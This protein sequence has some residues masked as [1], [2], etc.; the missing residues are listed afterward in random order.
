MHKCYSP[1][2]YNLDKFAFYHFSIRIDQLKI[3]N[4]II[5]SVESNMYIFIISLCLLRYI[6]SV[7]TLC[8]NIDFCDLEIQFL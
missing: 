2:Q 7:G 6:L 1:V 5:Q 3:F 4:S 8:D